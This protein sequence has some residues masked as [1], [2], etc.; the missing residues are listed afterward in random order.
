MAYEPPSGNITSTVDMFSWINTLVDN[1]FFAGMIISVYVIIIIKLMFSTDDL[2][3]S[4]TT[5]S[6]ICM[7]LTVFLRITNLVS[8]EL[9]VIFIIL[10]AVGAIWMHVENSKYG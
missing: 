7:I 3:K 6:F 1:W 8:T 2:G 5:A 4:F 9:M 10:T